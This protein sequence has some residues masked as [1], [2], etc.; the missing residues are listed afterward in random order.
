MEDKQ[1]ID[2]FLNRDE[3]AVRQTELKYSGYLLTIALNILGNREDSGECV[4]DTYFKAWNSIPP[5]LPARLRYYL[6]KITREL[7]IDR[8]RKKLSAKRGGK[9]RI[10]EYE[11][12]L[13]EL[14]ECVPQK[15]SPEEEAEISLLAEIISRY[16]H[17]CSEEMRNT[18]MLRYYFCDSIKTISEYFGMSESKVKSILFRARE[19]LRKELEKEGFSV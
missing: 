18:F 12:S 9:N 10:T 8:L 19:G 2:L 7:S 6:G 16:L 11:L 15:G 13:D 4:N 1:I 3:N 5:H 14:G 17:N